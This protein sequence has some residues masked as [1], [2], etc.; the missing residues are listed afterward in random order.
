MYAK[1]I[2]RIQPSATLEMTAKAAE[3]RSQGKDVIN[4]S[5]GEPDFPTPKNIC[6]A[7]IY[8]ME[9]GYT[10]YTPGLGMMELR[11]AVCE[12]LKRDN[13]LSYSPDNVIVSCG[14]KHSL[15]NACQTLFEKNDEVIIFTPYWVSFPDFISVTGAKPIIV[16]TD[17]TQQYEPNFDDLGE[18][19]TSNTKGIIINSPSNPTGGVWRD[20]AM[21]KIIEIAQAHNLWLFSDEC[22]EQLVYDTTFKSCATF[23]DYDKIVTFQSCS[24]TYAMTGWRIGYIAGREDLV[25]G[26]SKLQ[27]QSTS[28]PNSIAQYAAIEAL[29]GPQNQIQIMQ[30]AFKKRRDFVVKKLNEIDGIS[31]NLPR[32]AFYV[33]P[34]IS[35]LLNKRF[36]NI[37]IN[38]P[39]D[40]SMGLV[41]ECSIITVSGESFG[42]DDNIRLSYA[43]S[44][45]IL[46]NALNKIKLFINNLI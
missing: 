33:F 29:I 3:L 20:N 46:E 38:T 6:D 21:K 44:D 41:N 19:I 42:S 16:Q 2:N 45:A 30:S 34:N 28:C 24:K 9:N 36:N 40:L 31:C 22:Y 10:K 23:S 32:G 11:V 18:K 13:N 14:A 35:E 25:K 12:K 7:A 37:P 4:L 17:P 15:Y 43:T 26:M 1:R 27:G 39:N 5:V 8:A